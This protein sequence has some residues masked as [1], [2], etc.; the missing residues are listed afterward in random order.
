MRWGSADADAITLT[1]DKQIYAPGE[2][3][4]ILVRSPLPRGKYLLTLER[5]GIISEKIIDL[6]GSARTID[7]PIEEYY[8]PIVYAAISSYTVRSAPAENSYY[9][10]DLDKPK[11]IFGL[12]AIHVDN[13]SR[14]YQ[15][16]I[17]PGQGVYGPGEN[18]EVRL[19]VLLGGKPAPG[20]EL[21]FMAVDRGV[22]DLINYHVPDP[23]SFFYNPE[24]FPL[25]VR[26]AD[27]R[28]LLID[29]VTY[30]L[31]DL[32]G[33][34][35]EDESKL[36]ER[37][38]FRPTAVF[39]PYLVTGSDG[40]VR[41]TFSLPDSLTTYRC[42]AVAV[43]QDAARDAGHPAFGIQERDLRVSAPM[44]ALIAG[45]RK[46]RWRD[47]AQVSLILTNLENT[48]SDARITLA[49]EPVLAPG[50]EADVAPDTVLEVD[51]PAEQTLKVQPGES[52]EAAFRVAAV[53]SG[54]ARL[55]FTLRSPRVNERIVREI[56]VNRPQVYETV[57][58]MGNLAPGSSSSAAFIEEGLVIPEM[59]SAGAAED[60]GTL[61]VSLAASRLA[62][63]KD[64]VGY[65]LDYPYG[66]LEQR[67]ARLLPLVAFGDHLAAFQLDSPVG[68][69]RKVIEDELALLAKNR[70][71]DGSYPY[72]PGGGRGDYFVSLRV[73]HIAVLAKAKGY[74][75]PD[76]IDTTRLLTYVSSSDFARR[77]LS[78]DPFLQGYSLWVRALLG[79]KVG[80][81]V[82]TFLDR[83]DEI[84]I[85]GMSFA[86]LAALEL[87][88]RDLA[89][90]ARDRV[91][92][93]IR[94][95]TRSL[96]ITDTAESQIFGSYWNRESDKYA[97]ALMLYQALNPRDD[98]TTRLANSLID[99]QRQG[100]TSTA[101][102]FWA[103]LAFGRIG[104]DEARDAAPQ[105]A[106]AL[107]Q[108]SLGGAP[109]FTADFESYGGVPVSRIFA[110]TSP[111]LAA[112]A[113]NT[114]LPLRFERTAPASGGG[115]LYYTASLRY[116]IPAELAAVRDE[117]LGVFVE[118]LDTDGRPVTDG[119]LVAGK[120]YTRRVV[121]SSPRTRSYVAVRVPVPS[122]AEIV[123][124][125]FVTSATVPPVNS[126]PTEQD[127]WSP[128]EQPPLQFIMD[129]E[130]RFHWDHFPQ[131]KKEAV[132][133]FRAVMPGV[134]PTPPAAAECMYEGEVF[135]RAAG[136]LIIIR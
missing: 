106:R 64:A 49:I 96:D 124:A 17:E 100:R 101:S 53:G 104:D 11:G 19:R 54:R 68:D 52:I 33:G 20:V 29:P 18:A 40:T 38:D 13:T 95:G 9:E 67:T 98:M 82:R 122:G 76:G 111:T 120:V 134:Y 86:G 77:F 115:P 125:S 51:G 12:T 31:S 63:L 25:G 118:T 15:I 48:P 35:S 87:D 21:S 61:S 1:T 94:P 7:I 110:F 60:T 90:T 42:T 136:E 59:A 16:E 65:L 14:H 131:G 45:P 10:P 93:F 39:E 44:T 108:V 62:L 71:P 128:R 133:R 80:S 121:V 66:C 130:V 23:L 88:M 75:V 102:T 46:L 135:G 107:A 84:G 27:S 92:R 105:T 58:V 47:T 30:A 117:G 97:L 41:V 109:L 6:D 50:A 36:E 24:N 85:S 4:K 26:G 72:W 89:T 3:A 129:D 103:V 99:R 32:Q 114:L 113:R 127:P 55:V 69:V 79:E 28:S 57:T 116:G 74:A 43:G 5:E 70:L 83:G 112:L 119:R 34:D 2:T 123:D 22:V 78:R 8:V 56:D 37:K 81:E 126:N 132:F 91:R 73:G